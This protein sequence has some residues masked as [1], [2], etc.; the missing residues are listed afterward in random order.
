MVSKSI[1]TAEAARRL[2]VSAQTVQKWVDGGSLTAWKTVGGHRRIDADAVE[3]MLRT[4]SL[5]PAPQALSVLLVEA[6]AEVAES[7]QRR[8]L[9]C[10]PGARVRVVG[11]GFE[12][13]LDTGRDVPD[14]LLTDLD[15]PGLNGQEMIARLRDNPATRHMRIVIFGNATAHGFGNGNGSAQGN[16]VEAPAWL[17]DL[18]RLPTPVTPEALEAVLKAVRKPPA[19]G[20]ER[21]NG[22]T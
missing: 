4:R 12:A 13:L 8:I 3:Q 19:A 22:A 14:L 16:G 10:E 1:T 2:G 20:G 18:P 7:L 17:H 11:N 5:A 21:S 9:T 15:L 6:D